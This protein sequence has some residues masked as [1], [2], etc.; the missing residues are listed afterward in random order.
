M[1]VVDD[2][3]MN[4]LGIACVNVH[5]HDGFAFDDTLR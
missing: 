3:F 2:S 5:H 1:A 4:L